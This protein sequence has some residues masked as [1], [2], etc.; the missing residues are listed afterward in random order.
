M[1]GPNGDCLECFGTNYVIRLVATS[2]SFSWV[3]ERVKQQSSRILL[4]SVQ[5]M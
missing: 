4:I 1:T 2:A 3:E 5:Y